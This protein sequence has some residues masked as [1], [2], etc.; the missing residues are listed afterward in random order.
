MVTLCRQK[1]IKLLV[2]FTRRYDSFYQQIKNKWQNLLGEVQAITFYYS[3]GI[4]TVGSHMLD[5]LLFLLGEC[6]EVYAEQTWRGLSGRLKFSK[7]S[8][9]IVP[10]NTKNYSIFEMNIFGDRARLDTINKPFGEYAYR[11]FIREKSKIGSYFISSKEKQPIKID[12]PRDYLV[13]ALQDL[14]SSV[15]NNREPLSSGT[16]ALK[17]L[18]IMHALLYSAGKN[19]IKISLPFN[20]TVSWLPESGG[21]IKR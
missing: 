11:Y 21:D 13:A 8:V 16:T 2:N 9:D 14:L 20:K 4:V 15:R 17:S 12:L 5:L 7:V 18:Q 10:M 1:K 3:G 6:Q 19:G